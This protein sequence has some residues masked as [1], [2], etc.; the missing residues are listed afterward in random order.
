MKITQEQIR[1]IIREELEAVLSEKD[2]PCWKGYEMVG[3]KMKDGKEVPN[4]VP[5]SK[6]SRTD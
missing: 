2:G 4:C 5:T 6:G 3:M 1:N